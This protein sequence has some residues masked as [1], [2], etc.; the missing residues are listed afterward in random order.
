[1]TLLDHIKSVDQLRKFTCSTKTK[2]NYSFVQMLG[3]KPMRSR[4]A[5]LLLYPAYDDNHYRALHLLN[6]YDLL[7]AG[8]THDRDVIDN[9]YELDEVLTSSGEDTSTE[10]QPSSDPPDIENIPSEVD[11]SLKKIHDH[12]VIR[13]PNP[14]TNTAVAR[15]LG[16]SSNYVK[17]F[18]DKLLNDR[19]LYLTHFGYHDKVQYSYN[20]L[21]GPLSVRY[22][23]VVQDF[24]K[25]P[26]EILLDVL[27]KIRRTPKDEYIQ[28]TNFF[29]DLV[30]MGYDSILV[31]YRPIIKDAIV[32]HNFYANFLKAEGIREF[33]LL[34]HD[35]DYNPSG[36]LGH[37]DYKN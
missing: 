11:P 7:C 29:I 27:T 21:C 9:P 36:Y 16:I 17:M 12:F 26:S 3:G 18:S 15:Y 22:L 32:E 19:L 34:N 8:I 24:K 23:S 25:R 14:K 2:A 20:D 5:T 30:R 4:T 31:R 37:L 13:F 6:D 1:M 10:G 28:S 35:V 33:D